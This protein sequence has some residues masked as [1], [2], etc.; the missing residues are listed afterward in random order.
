MSFAGKTVNFTWQDAS[1]NERGVSG[2]V[3]ST[4]PHFDP[5]QGMGAAHDI[6]EHFTPR[7]GNAGEAEAFGAIVWI[8]LEGGYWAAFADNPHTSR[9]SVE[10]H[11]KGM[12][13]EFG[14][15]LHYSDYEMAEP[16]DF[17]RVEEPDDE[18]GTRAI[19][20]LICAHAARHCR[21]EHG[22]DPSKRHCIKLMYQWLCSGYAK[23]QEF[24]G[25]NAPNMAALF[26]EL[27][28]AIDNNIKYVEHYSG[29]SIEVRIDHDYTWALTT[30]TGIDENGDIWEDG[31]LWGN[32]EPAYA[33][34]D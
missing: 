13:Q 3:M 16:L 7:A 12:G 29:D 2:W 24:Y 4:M 15:F 19:L 22:M 23:V 26:W 20:R 11:A 17:E 14:D 31:V 10:E 5:V 30:I 32:G 6:L 28:K 9:M 1:E 33:D 25:N 8:R 27:E 21:N 34:A 18:D